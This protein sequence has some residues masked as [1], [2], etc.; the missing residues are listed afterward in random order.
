LNKKLLMNL[1]SLFLFQYC[2]LFFYKPILLIL[3][4]TVEYLKYHD[5]RG[6]V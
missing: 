4:A 1:E 2:E 5:C 6:D 3:L